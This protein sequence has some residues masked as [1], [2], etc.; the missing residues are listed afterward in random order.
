MIRTFLLGLIVALF[1][2][3][4]MAQRILQV[5]R[6]ILVRGTAN[7][8]DVFVES[9]GNQLYVELSS[10]TLDEPLFD[11]F[12]ASDIRWVVIDTYGGDDTIFAERCKIRCFINS[13]PGEDQIFGSVRPDVIDG[14]GSNDVIF[15]GN[16]NDML[17]GGP[18]FDSIDGGPH[19]DL[20][21]GENGR[22]LLAGGDGSDIVMGGRA[23]D[24]CVGGT[25]PEGSL[26][27]VQGI[28]FNTFVPF[29][30]R[31]FSLVNAEILPVDDGDSDLID[32][33]DEGD[34]MVRDFGDEVIRD[35]FGWPGEISNPGVT[36][37][38]DFV[39]PDDFDFD[40]L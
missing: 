4:A 28:W 33:G 38:V 7:A 39:F 22:D 6:E 19:N 9:F 24:I 5:G 32:G 35:G 18:G 16:G 31:I 34:V 12:N 15:G 10:S 3:Q 8:E 21:D 37:R 26:S 36:D 13:G 40:A 14:G 27:T 20:I 30:I 25:F 29:E 2:T 11:I 1:S 17:F 23:Q